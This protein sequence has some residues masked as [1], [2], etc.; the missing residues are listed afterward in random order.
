MKRLF[1]LLLFIPIFCF[2]QNKEQLAIINQYEASGYFKIDGENIVASRVIDSVPGTKDEIYIKV[3]NYFART[4]NDA[5]SVIQTDDKENGVIIGKGIYDLMVC[6]YMITTCKY[7]SYH[8][9]RVDIK[10]GRVRVICSA[11]DIDV[12]QK[13]TNGLN[14]SSY[15]IIDYAP[16]GD[17][18]KFDKGKQTEAFIK[19]VDRMNGSIDALEK[20]L[21]EGSLKVESEDW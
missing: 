11:S 12:D 5:N 4:Y 6:N 16:I 10:D 17:K 19:L 2:G 3:K 21:K 14:K 13:G 7:K 20:S 1:L 8:I 18:R 9:I 15:P